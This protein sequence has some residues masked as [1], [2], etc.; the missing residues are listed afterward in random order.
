M[1]FWHP[2]MIL[3]CS[4][5]SYKREV[6]QALVRSYVRTIS[7]TKLLQSAV[8]G[9]NSLQLTVEKPRIIHSNTWRI[10]YYAYCI[11]YLY[12]F[13]TFLLHKRIFDI[14]TFSRKFLICDSFSFLLNLTVRRNDDDFN[15]VVIRFYMPHQS[16]SCVNHWNL[17][18]W[19]KYKSKRKLIGI[20]CF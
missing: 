15:V 12:Y 1:D 18:S 10:N 2:L 9:Y 7:H 20:I 17:D 5:T 6:I 8:T 13:A 4:L 3:G 11:L 19:S 14:R 16:I